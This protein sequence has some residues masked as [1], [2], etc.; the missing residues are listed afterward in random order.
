MR[1]LGFKGLGDIQKA[2][3]D[4]NKALEFSQSNL[5]AQVEN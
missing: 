1:G 3:D 4:L 5:W 2:K